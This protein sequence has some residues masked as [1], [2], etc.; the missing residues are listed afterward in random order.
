MGWLAVAL[1]CNTDYLSVDEVW[2]L[3]EPQAPAVDHTEPGTGSCR[4]QQRFRTMNVRL[5]IIMRAGRGSFTP[6][7]YIERDIH[8]RSP[9]IPSSTEDTD[10]IQ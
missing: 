7:I 1:I 8:G 4:Q 6:R 9:P 10:F 5:G 2:D 3:I